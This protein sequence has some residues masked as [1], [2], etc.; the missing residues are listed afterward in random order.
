MVFAP[1]AGADGS[2]FA[3]AV[4]R[5]DGVLVPFAAYRNGKWSRPWPAPDGAVEIPIALEDIPARWWGGTPPTL[6]WTLWPSD[7]KPQPVRAVAPIRYQAHCLIGVGLRTEYRSAR[8]IPPPPERPFPKDGVAVSGAVKIQPIEILEA[9]APEWDDFES[10]IPEAFTEAENRALGAITRWR[11]PVPRGVR[12]KTPTK[13]EALYRS[14]V[15]RDVGDIY[16]VEAV[17]RY[18]DPTQKD[19]CDLV[20]FAS[21][22]VRPWKPVK[23]RFDLSAAVTYCDRANVAFLFPFGVIRLESR[24]PAWVVQA[25]GWDGEAYQVIETSRSGTKILVSAFGGSCPRAGR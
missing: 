19:G 3:F 16:Y 14:S 9:R 25:G 24:E 23:E 10:R 6:T 8:A 22:W 20:T 5:R 7:G 2:S 1:G 21:G 12:P 11:H 18:D 15:G 13:I 17:R 4:L